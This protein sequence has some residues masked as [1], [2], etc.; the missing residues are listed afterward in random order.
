[1]RLFFRLL[2]AAQARMIEQAAR[3]TQKPAHVPQFPAPLTQ[4]PSSMQVAMRIDACG[5]CSRDGLS[6]IDDRNLLSGVWRRCIDACGACTREPKSR[7]RAGI[8][9]VV[10]QILSNG[11]QNLFNSA[12]RVLMSLRPNT[13]RSVR[14]G[15]APHPADPAPLPTSGS[16]SI[17]GVRNLAA[18]DKTF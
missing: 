9:V 8:S 2:Y 13:L 16:A 4:I 11:E 6:V 14:I 17:S 7:T 10:G 15:D 1:M 5:T 12:W 18:F 3:M